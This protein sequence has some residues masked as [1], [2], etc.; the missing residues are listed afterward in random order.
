MIRPVLFT[1]GFFVSA[2]TAQAAQVIFT[3]N[4]FV[5]SSTVSGYQV[6]DPITVTYTS[7]GDAVTAS[8]GGLYEWYEEDT[9]DQ[10]IFTNV[11]L[12]GASGTW[13]RPN[14]SVS[15]PESVLVVIDNTD[16]DIAFLGAA[17]IPDDPNARNGLT[18]GSVPVT[19]LFSQAQVANSPFVYGAAPLDVSDYF[20]GYGGSYTLISY[21]DT[22]SFIELLNGQKINFSATNLTIT[23][24]EPSTAL[25]LFGSAGIFLCQ[26]RRR[27]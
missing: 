21:A 12:S 22:P 8:T 13:V 2:F 3:I 4:G 27:A 23:V 14:S 16:D 26:R 9:T 20:S 11:S 19:T 5:T 7:S 18:I 24:P 10:P 1:L 25:V 15:A 17:D 6:N